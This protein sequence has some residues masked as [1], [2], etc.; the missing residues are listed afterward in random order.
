MKPDILI[1]IFTGF[2]IGISGGQIIKG[3]MLFGR[4]DFAMFII[5]CCGCCLTA[6]NYIQLRWR[7]DAYM[8]RKYGK[9]WRYTI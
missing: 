8:T 2:I 3:L 5:F 9:N 6:L 7:F 4:L 1:S